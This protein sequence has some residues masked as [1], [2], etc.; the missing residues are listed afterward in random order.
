MP[1]RRHPFNDGAGEYLDS[2]PWSNFRL[3]MTDPRLAPGFCAHCCASSG[4]RIVTV[5]S[6]GGLDSGP[7]SP[8]PCRPFGTSPLGSGW[9]GIRTHEA[10]AFQCSKLGQSATLPTIQRRLA[11]VLP[12]ARPRHQSSARTSVVIFSTSAPH[13]L[14]TASKAP[15]IQS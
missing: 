4:F 15:S 12:D 7:R 2:A 8:L 5:G 6:S 14:A 1:A 10:Y 3:T 11:A 9:C 13:A